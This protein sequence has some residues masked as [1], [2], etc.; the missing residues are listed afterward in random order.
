MMMMR[1]KKGET[2]DIYPQT[3]MRITKY[4]GIVQSYSAIPPRGKDGAANLI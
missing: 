3:T 1:K 2:V 4:N